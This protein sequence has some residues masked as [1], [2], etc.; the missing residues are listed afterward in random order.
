MPLF[1]V[2]IPTYNRID[3]LRRTLASV[4]AQQFT[5]YEVIVVDDSS[6][7]GTADF[8]RGLGP[9]VKLLMQSHRGGPGLGRNV[10]SSGAHGDYVAFLDSDDL[11][12]PWTLSSFADLIE[13]YR[14]PAILSAKLTEFVEETELNFV[15]ESQLEADAFPDYF[16]SQG[17]SYFVGAGMSVLRREAFLKTGGYTD[18]LINAEDHD[19][20]LRM[21]DLRGFVQ[22]TSPVTL[23]WR[24][25]PASAT[26]N[27]QRSWA[28]NFFLIEQERRGAYPGGS[29]RRSARRRI[30]TQHVRPTALACLREGRQREAWA[31][32]RATF[33]WH[34][35][36]GRV[37]FL[38]AFPLLA[39]A[40]Q[41]RSPRDTQTRFN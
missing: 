2:V 17:N 34:F 16:A 25:H 3:L 36:M 8:V 39:V 27:L 30:V 13:I 32:Y 31:L 12:F 1:S 38:V 7:D 23:G 9:R 21:G 20:I 22:I 18:K 35:R 41:F 24:R 19:L 6:T 29:A 26:M 40:S 33:A 15:V 10:G 11:W 5:D 28:G 14:S 4:W 37:K